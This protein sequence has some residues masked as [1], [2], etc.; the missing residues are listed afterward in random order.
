MLSLRKQAERKKNGSVLRKI[1]GVLDF[2]SNLN[3]GREGE[4]HHSHVVALRS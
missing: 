1:A 3:H 2:D 4:L